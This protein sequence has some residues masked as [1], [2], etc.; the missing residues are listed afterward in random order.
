MIPDPGL[1][2]MLPLGEAVP[3]CGLRERGE[4]AVRMKV[5]IARSSKYIWDSLRGRVE[6]RS[7]KD[8]VCA[9]ERRGKTV[10]R[11]PDR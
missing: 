8:T 7:T 10:G 5:M 11:V 9:K 2:R 3:V 6:G 4:R 1:A